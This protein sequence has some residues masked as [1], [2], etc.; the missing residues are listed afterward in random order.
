[1][2]ERVI[3]IEPDGPDHTPPGPRLGFIGFVIALVVLIGATSSIASWTLDYAWWTEM[4]QIDT[5]W[6]Q[7]Y[8]HTA[9]IFFATI[10]AY[11]FLFIVHSRAIS[12]AGVNIRRYP[13][14]RKLSS[15]ALLPVSWLI[16]AAQWGSWDVA[17]WLGN[18][19]AA[20]SNSTGLQRATAS[21][22]SSLPP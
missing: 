15:I 13:F 21:R 20:G 17:L 9:P 18:R 14:Y 11:A 10:F 22:C 5:W 16:A 3:D 6:R 4:G 2:P 7:L 1:M 8:V 12:A 19:G